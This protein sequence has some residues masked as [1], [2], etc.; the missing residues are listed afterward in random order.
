MKIRYEFEDDKT[1]HLHCEESGDSA[2][3]EIEPVITLS[4]EHWV[5]S[6]VNCKG[7]E[8]GIEPFEAKLFI[9]LYRKEFDIRQLIHLARQGFSEILRRNFAKTL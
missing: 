5:N 8:M 7:E 6:Y 2:I 3:K 1:L 4:G 9:H